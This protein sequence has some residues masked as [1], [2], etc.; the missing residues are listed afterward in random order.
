MPRAALVET[1]A[2]VEVRGSW[3]TG[4]R[5][6]VVPGVVRVTGVVRVVDMM[7]PLDFLNAVILNVEINM[8]PKVCERQVSER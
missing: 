7:L 8:N 3:A 1:G 6:R 4:R 2:G 5:V